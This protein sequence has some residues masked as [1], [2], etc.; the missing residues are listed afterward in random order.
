[1]P[2]RVERS[3]LVSWVVFDRQDKGNALSLEDLRSAARIIEAECSEPST[4]VVAL[5]GAGEKFFTT[6]VDLEE[7]AAASGDPEAAW[8]LMYEGLGGL[9][10]AA[11]SCSKP[12][13]AAVNGYALGAGF[14]L[15]YVA[16]LAYAVR[17]AKLGVPPARYGMVPPASSTIGVL[18]ANSKAVA[19]LALTGQM[20]TA[21]EAVKYGFINDVVDS[22]EALRAKVNE[23]AS[24]IAMNDREAVRQVRALMAEV[25]GQALSDKGLRTLAAFTAR[26]VVGE[27]VKE[28]LSR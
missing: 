6:G 19:Y 11:F 13:I 18:L 22:T 16:D 8:R 26:K 17:W 25:K 20:I 23:V 28:F 9:C 5:T 24:L 12:I 2:I 15:L 3:D 14:E 4:T 21:E 27:R 1:M 7:T 10:R